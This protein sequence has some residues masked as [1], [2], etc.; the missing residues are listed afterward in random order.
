MRVTGIR[1]RGVCLDN[2]DLPGRLFP[3]FQRL[4]RRRGVLG[5][6]AHDHADPAVEGSVHLLPGDPAGGLEPMEDGRF[7]P[8]AGIDP[9]MHPGGQDPGQVLQDPAAGDMGN[10]LD[11]HLLDEGQDGADIDAGGCE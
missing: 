2:A 8:G 4:Y 10:G 1:M 3:F 11:R 6:H 5:G 9:G 7:G